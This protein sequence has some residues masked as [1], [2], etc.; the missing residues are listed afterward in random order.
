VL[1]IFPG[2]I[3]FATISGIAAVEMGL[4]PSLAMAMSVLVFAGASQLAALQLIAQAAPL[5]VIVST[6]LIINLRFTMY[7]ASIAPCF[8]ALSLKWKSLLAY[9]LTDPAYGLSIAQFREFPGMANKQWFY[10]GVAASS[11]L[12]WQS[13]TAAGI[14]L[15]AHVPENWSL[16]FAVPLMF[17]ALALPALYDRAT[18][19]AGLTAALVSILAAQLPLNLGLIVAALSGILLGVLID[20]QQESRARPS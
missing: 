14:F 8:R 15:G 7:S 19:A 18:L 20:Q 1:P 5:A 12:V 16:D 9:L 4:S 6:A 17:I 2:I 3:P 10:L 13:F 11:W